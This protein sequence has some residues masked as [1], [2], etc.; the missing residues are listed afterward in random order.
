MQKQASLC[1]PTPYC[2]CRQQPIYAWEME[3]VLNEHQIEVQRRAR[4]F[5]AS[6]LAPVA[7]ELDRRGVIP[8]E[9]IRGA[10]NL[11]LLGC[12]SDFAAY[13]AALIEISKE[14][15]ALAAVISVHN[16]FVCYPISRFGTAQQ[17]KT[18][19]SMITERKQLGC[20]AFAEPLAGSDA[21]A[22]RTTAVANGDHFVLN[23]H[24]RFVTSGRQ[25]RVAIV[26]ALTDPSKGREGLSAFIVDTYTPGFSRAE[27]NEMLGLRA[28]E[29]VDVILKDCKVPASNLLGGLNQ[30]F[31]IARDV[32]ERGRIDIAAQAIGIA[33]ACLEQSIAKAKDRRQFGRPIA[34]FEAIQWMI[35][36]MSTEVDAASLLTFRAASMR[37]KNADDS[38]LTMAAAMA[39]LFASEAAN[40]AAYNALQIFGGHGYLTEY[41]VERYFR[42]ARA[43]TLYEETS[44]IQRMVIER[45]LSK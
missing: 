21:G 35:A 10:A 7:V 9:I 3:F 15:A 29:A 41:P 17:K 23:G 1:A 31:A 14:W 20:Y 18:Y 6:T 37:A 24:K 11:G 42:D 26:Y 16:S 13:I 40:R 27:T 39:K 43:M 2:D 38:G 30:G 25:A 34:E 5:A 32:V 22:I 12:E 45:E 8:H 33:R 28:S 19:L 44:E 36:D 4:E